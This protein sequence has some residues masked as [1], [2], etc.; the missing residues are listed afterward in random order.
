[1]TS[2]TTVLVAESDTELAKVLTQALAGRGWS[3]L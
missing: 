3:V 2:Q 1:M